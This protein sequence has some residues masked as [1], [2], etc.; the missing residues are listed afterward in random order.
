MNFKSFKLAV[1]KQFNEMAKGTL[2]TT[3]VPKDSLWETYLKS[4]PE[5]TNPIYRERTEHDCNCCRQFIKSV[6]N[7]VS[8]VNNRLVSIWDIPGFGLLDKPYEVVAHYLSE[9]VKSY[10]IENIFLSKEKTAG[11]DKNN[12]LNE[13]TGNVTTF[14]HFFVNIPILYVNDNP[15]SILSDKKA[16]YDVFKRSLT[17]IPTLTTDI[18]LELISQNSLYRGEEH[19]H[20]LT[21]FK[22]HQEAFKKLTEYNKELYIWKCVG[23]G[24]VHE[25]LLRIRN[26]SI[27]RLLIDITEGT[28]LERAVNTFELM[29]APA[30]YKRPTA[31]VTTSMVNAA[32]FAIE[33]LGLTSALERRYATID[34]I[35]VHNILFVGGSSRE[36]LKARTIDAFENIA[37]PSAKNFSNVQEMFIES[38]IKN[39]LPTVK[40]VEILLENHHE[41]N[42]VSLIAPVDPTA[43]QLFK[44]SN[45]FSWSY[46]GDV[47]DAIKERVKQAGGSVEGDLCCRLAW[48]NYDDLDL[49]MTEADHNIIYYGQ[50][51]SFS[52]GGK[53]DVDMN[54]GTNG[55]TRTPVEN[56][57]YKSK[58]SMKEGIY[59]L[60][61]NQFHKRENADVGFHVD[62][63]IEGVI[64]H[65]E[66]TKALADR[67]TV[68]V[69]KLKYSKVEGI[70]I[71][72]SLLS[73]TT[74]KSKNMWNLD[75]NNFHK[76]DVMMLSPNFW[77]D[78][79]G[80]GNKHYFF[81]LS[82]CRNDATAR[83]F[84][85]EFLRSDL[86]AYRKTLEIV[87][88]KMKTDNSEHQLSGIGFSSTQ[89]ST[90]TVKVE[91]AISRILKIII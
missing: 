37:K 24:A 59:L 44:W 27:G 73:S 32:K 38:F 9:I 62:I 51:T 41:K 80:I 7:V 45:G 57:F 67:E 12:W 68:S 88:N 21:T 53:L 58:S 4:F 54:A 2:Y 47:A 28:P 52:T 46:K 74:P 65:F 31:I 34:D 69:A 26:T 55:R 83:G 70:T 10:P 17:E 48:F 40:S 19:K 50:P 89:R 23:C 18:V 43:N 64:H 11:T 85:N 33:A 78:Q 49:R 90:I 30:N 22:I 84:Y 60:Q 25:S 86:D 36:I 76:V 14:E 8:I 61:V 1:A 29:V 72:E 87:G 82:G 56:I 35:T 63:D 91:G 39:V 15:G 77:D 79:K 75:T 42:L 3:S 20:N 6:G 66:Y 13:E 81:M 5:G 71:V 16:S